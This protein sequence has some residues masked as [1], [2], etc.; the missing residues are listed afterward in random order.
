MKSRASLL[1]DE[2]PPP[3]R[4]QPEHLPQ[5]ALFVP[6]LIER[7]TGSGVNSLDCAFAPR[8]VYLDLRE[9]RRYACHS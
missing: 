3:S 4:H 9:R 2:V 6:A 1:P 5:A 8:P 7:E